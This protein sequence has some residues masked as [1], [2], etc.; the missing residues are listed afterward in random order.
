MRN[1]A[2]HNH[3]YNYKLQ[4]QTRNGTLKYTLDANYT[5]HRQ[6]RKQIMLLLTRK[7]K[8]DKKHSYIAIAFT[9][10]DAPLYSAIPL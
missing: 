7:T 9:G 2:N 3:E 10:L 6:N 5:I 1:C 8:T 4:S